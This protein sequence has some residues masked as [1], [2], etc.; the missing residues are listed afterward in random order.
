M[1]YPPSLPLQSDLIAQGAVWQSSRQSHT[2]PSHTPGSLQ[3]CVAYAVTISSNH[4]FQPALSGQSSINTGTIATAFHVP[5]RPPLGPWL[6]VIVSR[7]E[8]VSFQ[9]VSFPQAVTDTIFASQFDIAERSLRPHPERLA[10]CSL[11]AADVERRTATQGPFKNYRDF[12]DRGLTK[13]PVVVRRYKVVGHRV[14]I[15]I[16]DQ[17]AQEI[18]AARATANSQ[19]VDSKPAVAREGKANK[20]NPGGSKGA[21][22]DT[23]PS[24]ASDVTV[25]TALIGRVT[26][27]DLPAILDLLPD[28]R[29]FSQ[30]FISDE[31][32]PEDDWVTQDYMKGQAPFVSSMAALGDE[33]M[34][35]KQ[36][37]SAFLCRDFLHEWAHA[38]RDKYYEDPLAWGFGYS[39]DLEGREWLARPYMARSKG[40]QW[41]VL[42]ERLLGQDGSEFLE[43]CEKAPL[44][45][46]F[47]MRALEKCLQSVDQSH[48]S[49]YHDRYL[50]RVKFAKEHVVPNAVARVRR[51]IVEG[52]P[53]QKKT[54]AMIWKYLIVEGMID[55]NVASV[56]MIG[57]GLTVGRTTNQEL[58]SETRTEPYSTPSAEALV[59]KGTIA[60]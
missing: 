1:L 4:H 36:D 9:P 42:G 11:E 41:A 45:T 8:P 25:K 52:S 60:A 54:A 15:V 28:S 16:K 47:F 59:E 37:R 39:V 34:L 56:G 17:F 51:T 48:R 7:R 57:S 19:F 26:P 23:A 6:Q 46:A 50:E 49:I 2:D 53:G 35:F 5:G 30:I 55:R 13:T 21:A 40:D 22:V 43:A 27:E 29:Y 20:A 14:T 38:L 24:T 12:L 10:S 18:E 31:A 44:R 33:V 32:N 3:V 58:R